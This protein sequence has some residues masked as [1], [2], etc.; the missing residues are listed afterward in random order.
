MKNVEIKARCNDPE[1]IEKILNDIGA[2]Y[3]GLDRQ[4]D[5]YFKVNNGRLKLREGNIENSLIFYNRPNQKGPKQSTFNLYKSKDLDELKPLLL[6][7][8]GVLVQVKK[9][10]KI[11]FHN[12]VKFHID[13]VDGLGSFVEIE[14][15]DVEIERTS[16]ELRN[17][18]NYYIELLGIKQEDMM[19][20]SYSD[21]LI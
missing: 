9:E 8:L 21:M 18:C 4:V 19:E 17:L 5:T 3:K 12:Y 16:E 15:G 2:D 11:F 1:K 10:R 14:S 20:I 6:N 13:K 7:S